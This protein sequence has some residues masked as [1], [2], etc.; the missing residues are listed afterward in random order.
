MLL[1]LKNKKFGNIDYK[2][3]FLEVSEMK[4][5][6]PPQTQFSEV[7]NGVRICRDAFA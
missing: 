2:S 3:C 6:E 4:F 5:L 1:R 7:Q